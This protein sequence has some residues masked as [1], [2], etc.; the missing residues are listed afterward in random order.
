MNG[1]L[2]G[3]DYSSRYGVLRRGNLERGDVQMVNSTPYM[4]TSY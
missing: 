4:H 3:Y 1:G 2:L